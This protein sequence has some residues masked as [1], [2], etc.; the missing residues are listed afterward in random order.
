[1]NNILERFSDHTR[2]IFNRHRGR[3]FLEGAMA[4]SALVG[5]SGFGNWARDTE[6]ARENLRRAQDWLAP[7]LVEPAA[8]QSGPGGPA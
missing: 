3:V 1:M 5:A 2:R 4:A 8:G 7:L 6:V